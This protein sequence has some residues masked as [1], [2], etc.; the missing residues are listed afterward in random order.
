MAQSME[1]IVTG[2]I[3]LVAAA[4]LAVSHYLREHRRERW[5]GRAGGQRLWD[6]ARHR[7]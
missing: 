3:V 5:L 2:V 1:G 4:I 7:H 6:R